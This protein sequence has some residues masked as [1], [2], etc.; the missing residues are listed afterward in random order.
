MV[1]SAPPVEILFVDDSVAHVR[2]AREALA[3]EGV[4]P[5]HLTVAST[6]KEALD[7]LVRRPPFENTERPD[8]VLLDLDLPVISGLDVLT[9]VKTS[10]DLR[11]IPVVVLVRSPR[12]EDV[13]ECYERGANS[14]VEYPIPLEQLAETVRRVVLYWGRLNLR[15]RRDGLTT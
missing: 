5:Y 12:R 2:I 3:V 4:P 8:V 9:A 7:R 1:G 14:V 11:S 13:E 6:G 15:E 10:H